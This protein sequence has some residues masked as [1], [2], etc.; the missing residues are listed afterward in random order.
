MRWSYGLVSVSCASTALLAL[1]GYDATIAVIVG[2]LVSTV[3]WFFTPARFTPARLETEWAV[4]GRPVLPILAL[5]VLAPLLFRT[6]PFRTMHGGV[7][8]AYRRGDPSRS[9]AG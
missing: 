9:I 1:S 6:E 4:P 5:V 8:R 7:E 2:T 3:V